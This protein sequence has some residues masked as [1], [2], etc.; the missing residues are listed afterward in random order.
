MS[1]PRITYDAHGTP[2]IL[3]EDPVSAFHG[4]GWLHGRHRPVQTL[5]IAAAARGELA[6]TI[7]PRGDL[8]DLDRLVHRHD[9]PRIGAS[10]VKHLAEHDRRCLDAFV[11]GI[12]RAFRENGMP[13]EL[14]VL[15]CR[16]PPP[17]PETVLSGF[18][19]SAFLGLAQA[20]ERMERALVDALSFGADATLLETIFAPH[21]AGWRPEVLRRVLRHG[22][23]APSVRGIVQPAGG[24]NA[25]AVGPQRSASGK[26]LLA[27]D[28]HL[29]ANQLPSLMFEVRARVGEDFWLG[30]TIP[31]LPG[32]GVGR[33]RRVAWSGTFGVAD[34]VDHWLEPIEGGVLVRD[35]KRPAGRDLEIG[36]RFLTSFRETL[37]S[38][39]RGALAWDGNEDGTTLS[40]RWAAT[41]AGIA[42]TLSAYMRLASSTSA[43][44]AERILEDAQ[45]LTLHFVLADVSGDVR[46]VQVGRIPRR[47]GG[48][49]GLYPADQ[50]EWLGVYTGKHLPHALAIDGIEASANEARRGDDG[51][52]LS[53]FAQPPYRRTRIFELLH[54][55]HDHDR[56]SMQAIQQDLFSLQAHALRPLFV[57]ALA[58]GPLRR[59]LAAW[60]CRYHPDSVGPHA[61]ELARAAA[62][63]ALAPELG[64]DWF[65]HMLDESE[66]SV[67]WCTALDRLL[68]RTLSREETPAMRVRAELAKITGVTSSRWGDVQRVHYTNLI[69]GGLPSWLR[70][71]AG[72]YPLPGSIATVSQGNV[73]RSEGTSVCVAPVYRF[74]TDLAEDAAW[75]SVPGGVDGSRFDRTYLSW[76]DE[77][78]AGVYHRIAPPDL[79]ET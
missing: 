71:D 16:I 41:E 33:N 23:L 29:Q 6:K 32:V 66:L 25:W 65:T 28:P 43:A 5:L 72:P 27:G 12:A 24:S 69:L 10:E 55:R 30:A 37:W 73:V 61:F 54:A 35:G 59:T 17:S 45:T 40:A 14:R 22:E 44:D 1:V 11:D 34:N 48:W 15:G 60:D 78:R 31:G 49:S 50:Q 52:T 47:S 57:Q 68:S 67:W 63:R 26:P 76:L 38:S 3:A 58:D 74:V 56:A 21:L 2:G 46:Y 13:I 79:S 8:L 42:P 9:I 19:V 18:L 62:L 70:F 53:T 75:T 51:A 64:G 39:P 7:L 20:Q 77:H 4:L 36:R